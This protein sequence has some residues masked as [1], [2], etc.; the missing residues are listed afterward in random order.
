MFQGRK[1]IK[2]VHL[3]L[4]NYEDVFC[5]ESKSN[6]LIGPVCIYIFVHLTTRNRLIHLFVQNS[7]PCALCSGCQRGVVNAWNLELC[8]GL[9]RC[10]DRL[11]PRPPQALN[12]LFAA[13]F[14]VLTALD[15]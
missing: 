6:Y 4:N 5:F 10:W 8:E 9:E 11:V 13:I 14:R 3:I 2:K 1:P 7:I 15:H 12:L